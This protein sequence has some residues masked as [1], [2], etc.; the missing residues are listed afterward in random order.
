MSH[1]GATSFVRQQVWPQDNAPAIVTECNVRRVVIAWMALL[2]EPR[3]SRCCR[4][5]LR[6]S[7][8]GKLSWR[9]RSGDFIRSARSADKSARLQTGP[10]RADV[11]GTKLLRLV[12]RCIGSETSDKLCMESAEQTYGLHWNYENSDVGGQYFRTRPTS[13]F[14]STKA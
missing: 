14:L 9:G 5:C 8:R 1:L 13:I 6:F 7:R 10:K 11:E 12:Y 2:S 3:H 4:H